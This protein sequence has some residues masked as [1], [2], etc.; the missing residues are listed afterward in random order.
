[1][2]VRV[3][4]EAASERSW[5]SLVCHVWWG[6]SGMGI[7]KLVRSHAWEG[8][9]RTSKQRAGTQGDRHPSLG[10]QDFA[11]HESR[12]LVQGLWDCRT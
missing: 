12:A 1:M 6:S 10:T 7:S 4:A 9:R 8:E 11:P 5:T 2:C 3:G